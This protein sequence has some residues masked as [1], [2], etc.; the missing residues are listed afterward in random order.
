M[1]ALAGCTERGDPLALTGNH[2]SNGTASVDSVSWDANGVLQSDDGSGNVVKWIRSGPAGA[3]NRVDHYENGVHQGHFTI[4]WS[5]DSIVGMRYHT[6]SNQWIETN[7]DGSGVV[8]SAS[9]DTEPPCDDGTGGPGDNDDDPPIDDDGGD[10]TGL[11]D[12]Q[13]DNFAMSTSLDGDDCDAERVAAEGALQSF[14]NGVKVFGAAA[15]IPVL[16]VPAAFYSI[17]SGIRTVQAVD[18]WEACL[19]NIA[20]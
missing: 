2:I 11:C 14:E 4:T 3:W 6:L 12:D 16:T 17:M 15:L 19:D 5:N 8:V 9:F 18:A 7:A 20:D 13:V 10:D 1:L